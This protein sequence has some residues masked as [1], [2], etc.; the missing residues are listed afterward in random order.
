MSDENFILKGL[1]SGQNTGDSFFKIVY[2]VILQR[3]YFY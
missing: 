2:C 3:D 1:L